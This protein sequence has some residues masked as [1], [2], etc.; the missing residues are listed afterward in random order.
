VSSK[1]FVVDLLE[2]VELVIWVLVE[3]ILWVS[4]IFMTNRFN[5]LSESNW[6]NMMN[7]ACVSFPCNAQMEDL[8]WLRRYS[9]ST[10]CTIDAVPGKVL[11]IDAFHVDDQS[12]PLREP[13]TTGSL[14]LQYKLH[15]LSPRF[16]L[17]P[18]IQAFNLP[19][20]PT[21]VHLQCITLM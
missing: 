6:D 14:C 3:L 1:I 12:C 13:G 21:W 4:K 20:L 18:S 17:Y 7:K 19:R 2:L 5:I 16:F 15:I 10:W 8:H 9:W 11:F